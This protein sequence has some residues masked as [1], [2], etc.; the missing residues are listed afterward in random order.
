MKKLLFVLSALAIFFAS[1]APA[2]TEKESSNPL[3][4]N[5][6]IIKS[7]NDLVEYVIVDGEI[8]MATLKG[9][10]NIENL[11]LFG[12]PDDEI[13]RLK[14]NAIWTSNESFLSRKVSDLKDTVKDQ[15]TIISH[16][17]TAIGILS[18]VLLITLLFS[19]GYYNKYRSARRSYA[20]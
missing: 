17:G 10:A 5:T 3:L 8:T 18:V 9:G 2:Q 12:V 14:D 19:I 15:E 7:S 11:S 13:P 20:S 6:V 1:T 16:Q 4:N